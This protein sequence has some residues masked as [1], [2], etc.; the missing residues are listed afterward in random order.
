MILAYLL[1]FALN[2]ALEMPVALLVL[3]GRAEPWRII[4]ACVAGN[5]LTHPTIHFALPHVL[6]PGARPLF[7]IVA[8]GF[9]LLVESLV[10]LAVA[11]PSSGVLALAAAAGSNLLSY[12]VGLLIK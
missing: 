2:L 6:D 1:V 4:V 3:R 9:V 5:V 11:R 10:Y 8:E 7:T 12:A